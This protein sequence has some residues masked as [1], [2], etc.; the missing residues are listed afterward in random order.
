MLWW[1]HYYYG[2]QFYYVNC[3]RIKK[4]VTGHCILV[5]L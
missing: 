5:I 1:Q 3:A 4:I 2:V